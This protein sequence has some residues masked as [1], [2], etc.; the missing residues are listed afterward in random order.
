[1]QLLH[2]NAAAK[3]LRVGIGGDEVHAIDALA[4]H[5]IDGVATGSADADDLDHRIPFVSL[6]CR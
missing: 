1:L 4:D 6:P 3:R 2:G 5:V